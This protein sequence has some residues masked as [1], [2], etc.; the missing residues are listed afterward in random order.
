MKKGMCFTP[1][2]GLSLEDS[3]KVYGDAG[4]DGVEL[5]FDKGYLTID[6]G[7]DHIRRIRRAVESAGLEVASVMAGPVLNWRMPI[8]HPDEAVRRRSVEGF[9]KALEAT[10]M[11]GADVLLMVPGAVTEETGYEEALERSREAV[12]EIAAKAE[13]VEV[14]LAVEN[15]ANR[16]LLSPLEMRGF[17]DSFANR[18]VGM[19]L[20]V[21][22][23][24]YCRAGYPWDWI[25]IMGR[26][27]KR[28]HVKDCTWDGRITYLLEG[29]VDWSRVVEAL[30]DVGYDSY[31]TA[32]L[33]P[34]RRHPRRMLE[35]T[36]KDLEAIISCR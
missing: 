26:R 7:V 25:R 20:D 30:K 22:N 32:E 34:Y 19:Y 35:R 29:D 36:V 24:L 14:Y 16:F 27:I 21:G 23:I 1:L 12:E 31:L 18:W 17:I 9:K 6:S 8:T 10:A 33:P 13:E 4:F 5:A 15:V 28:V 3:L 2:D 11:L